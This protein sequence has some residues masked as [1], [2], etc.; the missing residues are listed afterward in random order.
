MLDRWNELRA[1]LEQPKGFWR[2][3]DRLKAIRLLGR[4]PV[5]AGGDRRVAEIF[6]ATHALRR[7][8]EAFDDL[9]TDMSVQS[10]DKFVDE[11]K[12]RWTDLVGA[13][14]P[15]QARQVLIDLVDQSIEQIEAML[16]EH[17]QN[18]EDKNGRSMDRLGVDKGR[19]GEFFFRYEL[20]FS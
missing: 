17:G 18:P 14:K 6:A 1:F 15:E 20:R 4:N 2:S 11:I 5:H 16:E 13:G 7:T 19:D 8:G 10:H 12:A 3:S 9:L